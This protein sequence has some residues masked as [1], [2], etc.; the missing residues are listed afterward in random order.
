MKPNAGYVQWSLD[1]PKLYTYLFCFIYFWWYHHFQEQVHMM[2]IYNIQASW[3]NYQGIHMGY[4]PMYLRVLHC[5][6]TT[7][8]VQSWKIW[9]NSPRHGAYMFFFLDKLYNEQIWKKFG[10]E[11]SPIDCLHQTQFDCL[12]WFN[13]WILHSLIC[14]HHTFF[15]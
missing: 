10:M 12:I 15:P 3:Q 14:K 8:F 2:D 9:A 6:I 11:N 4:F 13:N 1:R 7:A 5:C